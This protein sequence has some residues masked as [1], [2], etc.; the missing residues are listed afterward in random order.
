M[1]LKDM[2]LK[3]SKNEAYE[4]LA[5]ETEKI[6]VLMEDWNISFAQSCRFVARRTPSDI[7]ADFLDRFAH[8][9]DSGEKVEDFLMTEQKVVMN[10]F[11]TMYKEALKAIDNIKDIYVSMVMSLIFIVSFAI[12]LPVIMGMDST[13]LMAGT[14]FLFLG[15]ETMIVYYAKITVPKDRL[16]HSLDIETRSDRA[17]RTAFPVSIMLC[18]VVAVI[19][20]VYGQLPV[21]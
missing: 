15:T 11:N 7:F 16:W 12:L 14:M 4:Y 18:M 2:F 3:L 6:Y 20:L 10:D 9:V 13:L 21:T 19:V 5:R 1:Q 8:A 17:I